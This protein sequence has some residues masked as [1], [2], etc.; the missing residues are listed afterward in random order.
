MLRQPLRCCCVLL[1]V[2]TATLAG[3]P[4]AGQEP[5]TLRVAIKGFENNITPFTVTFASNPATNDLQHLVYDSLFWSQ[6]KADPEPWLAES[7]EPSDDHRT[8]TVRVRDDVTWH[9]GEPFT[10]DDVQFSFEYYDAQAGASGRYAHHVNDVPDYEGSEIV[11]EHTIQLSFSQPAPQF[12]IMPGADLPI[13]AQHVFEGV[14][15]P[16]TMTTQLP[17][18]TGPFRLVD[19]EPDQRYRLEA[20]DDYFKGE[21]KVDELELVVIKDPSSAFTALRTGDVDMVERNVPPELVE[22]LRGDD[23]IGVAEGTRFES[24]QFYFN[25]RKPPIDDPR[26]RK[27]ISM[28]IDLE[29]I[30]ETVLLGHGAPGVD[31]YLHPESPW[32]V[33][34]S[35]HEHDTDAASRLLDEAGFATRDAD[36]VRVD[37]AG[38]RLQLNVLVS[39]FEPIE[40]RAMQLAATQLADLGVKLDVEPLDPA[41]LRQRRQAPPGEVPSYDT[42]VSNIESHAHVDPDALYYFFHSPGPKGFGGAITGYSNPAYDAIVEQAAVAGNDE[43]RELLAEAQEILAQDIP[44]Q[45]LFYPAGIWAYRASSYDGW[46]SDPGHGIFTKRSF[47]PGYEDLAVEGASAEG[48]DAGDTEGPAGEGASASD[49]GSD[50]DGEVAASISDDSGSSTA[51]WLLLAALVAAAVA[52]AVAWSRR[53]GPMEEE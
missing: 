44:L 33:E 27:A 30:V 9:D 50:V 43:R 42:Y 10:V 35:G 49:D 18:G 2:A 28:G 15:E 34:D 23:A 6:A 5:Q 16:G 51:T 46:V 53:R 45:V 26:V 21:V 38:T 37:D 8:W 19:I 22:Q 32:A 31:T 12:K 4:A 41:T 47:L 7:A 25:A 40:T 48:A 29:A 17:V 11:D 52:A 24:S 14:E 20:N 39:S 13:I 3:G 1:L 36:G